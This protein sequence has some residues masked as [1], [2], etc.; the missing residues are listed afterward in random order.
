MDMPEHNSDCRKHFSL[1]DCCPMWR[2]QHS[3]QKRR[4]A[5]I[6]AL[7]QLEIHLGQRRFGHTD[8]PAV[9]ISRKNVYRTHLIT[10]TSQRLDRFFRMRDTLVSY[11]QMDLVPLY[12]SK[13]AFEE[14]HTAATKCGTATAAARCMSRWPISATS[15]PLSTKKAAVPTACSTC[16]A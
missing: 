1:A 5:G 7:L 2:C 13:R 9:K 3:V 11:N 10:R 6:Q 4:N 14:R 15:C 16:S 12:Y 8:H